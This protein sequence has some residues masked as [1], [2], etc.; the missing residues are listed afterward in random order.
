MPQLPGSIAPY[1][2]TEFMAGVERFSR[3]FLRN[4][5]ALPPCLTAFEL[6]LH[7]QKNLPKSR[8]RHLGTP[9]GSKVC[10]YGKGALVCAAF[11]GVEFGVA[12]MY[13]S[14][15]LS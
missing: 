3:L 14:D 6:Y 11:Q 9:F 13:S 10:E 7:M 12:N 2:S 5:A 15:F 1:R 4:S 8:R